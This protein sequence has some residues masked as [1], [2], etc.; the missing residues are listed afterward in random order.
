[1]APALARRLALA[2]LLIY[3]LSACKSEPAAPP[4]AAAP[5]QAAPSGPAAEVPASGAPA[6]TPATPAAET[7][8]RPFLW[9]VRRNGKVSHLLGTIHAQYQLTH[10]PPAVTE[11][12]DAARTLVVEADVTAI[13]VPEVLQ[14]AMLP[15]GQSLRTMLGDA[16][17]RKLEGAVG[18][19]MP[20]AMLERLQPWFAGLLVSL[21]E[22]ALT[23]QSQVMDLQIFQRARAQE[24]RIVFLEEAGAQLALL[25]E[26]GDLDSLKEMLDELDEVRAKLQGM[27]AAYGRGDFEALTAATLD[28]EEM[29]ERPELIEKLLFQRNRA[30]MDVLA[31]LLAEGEVFV[32][33]GAGHFAGDKGLLALL[34]KAGYEVQRVAP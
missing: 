6:A 16:Y 22:V 29:R 7:I 4:P 13:S 31:P 2:L 11:R 26:S 17:W 27:L 32:A 19:M 1:M 15:P 10:L 34:R 20:P 30:W 28:A 23:D 25:T 5:E 12:L 21:G 18:T 24:K 14:R 33:V 8:A 9:E 3:L